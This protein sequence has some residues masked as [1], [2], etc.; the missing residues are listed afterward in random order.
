MNNRRIKR[1]SKT[2]KTQKYI[3]RK[4]SNPTKGEGKADGLIPNGDRNNGYAWAMAESDN[5]I[6]IG[7]NINI[8]FPLVKN[9]FNDENL[10]K[11]ITNILFKGD[12]PTNP[13]DNAAKIFRY[14]K[15]TNKIEL[16]YKSEYAPNGE[17]YEI[18]YRSAVPF[19]PY[20]ED[21]E[22]I[23]MGGFGSKYARILKFKKNY[24]IG[25]DK[26]E[27]VFIDNTGSSSIRAMTTHED[28]L[29]F[30]LLI[31]DTD[32]RVMESANP[33]ES[34]WN[35]VADL[36]DFNNIPS[37]NAGSAGAGGIFDLI[38]YNG[39]LYAIIGSGSKPIEESGFL[40]FKG[41]YLGLMTEGSNAYGW[42]WEMIVGPGG[43]Y[44]AGMGV[45]S[46]AIATP[47]KYRASDGKEY[48]Y[49]GTFSNVIQNAQ[50]LMSFDFSY[51]Y[52]NFVKPVQLYRFDENDNW[53][54]VIGTPEKDEPF[55]TRIGNY[56]AGF[57]PERYPLNYSSNHYIWRMAEYDGKLFLGTFDSSTLYDYLIP[58][59]IPDYVNSFDDI[60]ELLLEFL[61][62][63]E[64]INSD[65]AENVIQLFNDPKYLV[66]GDSYNS[67]N[68]YDEISLCY[69]C[70]HY[71]EMN[72]SD[73]LEKAIDNLTINYNLNILN[74]FKLLLPEDLNSKIESLVSDVNYTNCRNC[75]NRNVLLSLNS[76]ARKIPMSI[77]YDNDVYLKAIYEKLSAQFGDS[78][79]DAIDKTITKLNN[80]K[81]LLRDLL[82]EIE[83]YFTSDEFLKQL[84]YMK[85]TR[86]MLNTS[87][88]G[89]DFFVSDDGVN[90][91]KLNDNGFDDKFNYGIRTFIS[92]DDGLYIGTANPFYGAQLWKLISAPEFHC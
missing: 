48:V 86:R 38:S 55:Q 66:N 36:N 25:V 7:S 88:K 3:I 85:S 60:L 42:K 26:P 56:K 84:F 46:Y 40:I 4:L 67:R 19:K 9:V 76:I 16:V 21:T 71:H 18:G 72:P 47:F 30:G 11:I 80:N 13:T 17:A 54:M 35:I 43:K 49:V 81:G 69:A 6:Y 70:S 58:K 82:S 37:V 29:Y 33:N 79:V 50:K 83:A 12:V 15:K 1:C 73:Y 44:E 28:K 53:E 78:A 22:S 63:I 89:F 59:S 64:L 8:I 77:S 5:Y 74:A 52:K 65:A 92:S 57:V 91:S 75:L 34:T 23:Y 62:H 39:Y 90:F 32:L 20:N 68:N 45:P 87:K 61:S 31:N 10:A 27:V 51:L 2:I 24:V 41:K 14:N